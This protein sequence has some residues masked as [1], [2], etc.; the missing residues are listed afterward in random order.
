MAFTSKTRTGFE[1]SSVSV[2]ERRAHVRFPCELDSSCSPITGSK[3][4][5]WTGKVRD[6]SRGGVGIVLS[7]RFELGTLLNVEILEAN[8]SS[9]G[10]MLARV[11]H[12]TP[13]TSGGWMI[14]CCFTSELGD[15]DVKL[16]AAD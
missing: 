2:E 1:D 13:H 3:D 11:V 7:R 8:G 12:V 16:F 14:G 4:T 15:D 6:I 10:S 9:S 5:Q